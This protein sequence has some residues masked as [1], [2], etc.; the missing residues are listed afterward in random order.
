M[1][2]FTS[3]EVC[4]GAGGQA[5]G[6]EQAGFK[7][8]ALVD[9]D[10]HCCRTLKTNRPQ[11]NVVHRDLEMFDATEH[12]GVDLFAGGLPCPPF[13]KAGKQLGSKDERNLFPAALKRIK[14]CAPRAIM[15]ENVKG[16]LDPVFDDY[17]SSI[18][19]ELLSDG[20]KVF[21]G[22]VNA[23]EFG[24]PQQRPRAMLVAIQRRFANG[25]ELPVGTTAPATVGQ[26]LETMMSANGWKGAASWARNADKIAPTI[27]GGSKKHGGPDLGPTGAKRAWQK[28]GVNGMTIAE[29]APDADF[30]KDAHPR[31]TVQMV[32]RLQGFPAGWEITGKKTPAYRQVGNA[33]PPPVAREVAKAISNALSHDVSIADQAAG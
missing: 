14:E 30:P 31:L 26:T 21:W 4:A 29:C 8:L 24:V 32:A 33:F 22:L 6:L 9:N 15:I 11:W 16:L 10:E 20:Y 5:I 18:E 3:I 2:T 25:F 12:K 7:H 23:F 1:Q 13:S 17:R 28:L 19:N 27:V